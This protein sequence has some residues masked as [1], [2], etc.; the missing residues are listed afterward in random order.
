MKLVPHFPN[1]PL[2]RFVELI[3]MVQGTASH[4]REKVLPN[5]AIELILNIGSF[6]KVV[7]KEDNRQFEIYRESWIAGMQENYILIE[8][9]KESDLIGIRFRPGGAYPFFRFPMSELTNK[10]IESDLILGPPIR[11]LRQSLLEISSVDQRIRLIE[12][13]LLKRID[14]ARED[15][16]VAHALREIR[17]H[18]EH[19]S[20]RDLSREVGLSQKHLISRFRKVAG[21]SPKLLARIFRF[22]SVINYVRNQNR[23]SWAEVAHHCNYYDQAHLIREFHLLSDAKPSNYLQHRD[24]DENHIVVQ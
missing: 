13:F 21:I 24:E 20:I 7:S 14:I 10:V 8:A 22:Q 12:E 6:H 5:G 15:L 3:W 17:K 4:N 2:S 19:R 18:D 1:P 23:V 11:N 16:L 9:L